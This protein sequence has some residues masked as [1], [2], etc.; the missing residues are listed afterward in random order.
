MGKKNKEEMEAQRRN[1]I[2][3][4]AERGVDGPQADGIFD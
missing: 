1:F 4:A 2:D 3:G